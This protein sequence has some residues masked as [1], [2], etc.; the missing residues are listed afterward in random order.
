MQPKFIFLV[1]FSTMFASAAFAAAD[2]AVSLD[3]LVNEAVAHNPELAFYTAEIDAARAGQRTAA[4][5]ADP[6]LTVSGGQKRVKDSTGMLVGEGAAWSV[7]IAQTFDWPGR[8]ALRKSIANRQLALA[9]LGLARFQAALRARARTLAYGLLAAQEKAAAAS[10]VASRYAAL[11]EVFLQREPAGL[12][13]LLE[14]R[15]IEAQELALQRRATTATLAAQAALVELNQLRGAALDANLQAAPARLAFNPA[16]DLA[17]LLAAARENNFEYRGARLELEAQGFSVALARN[18]RRPSVMVAPF[19]SQEKAGDRETT[20]GLGLTIPLSVG[21]RAGANASLA[22]ARRR[23][24][25]A[26]AVVAQ[27]QMEREVIIAAQTF[28]VKMTEVGR[29]SPDSAAK[30]REAA[31][32]A[33]R[34]Y[35]LGAVPLATY[36]EL[37]NSYLD[38][39]EALYETQLE[40]LAAGQQLELLTGLNFRAAELA[41]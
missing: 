39:V 41:P 22:E 33:D 28:A 32:L 34:H 19:L 14:T 10:E 29:W 1:L 20:F 8:L 30:F 18:E 15:V 31:E 17:A 25:E 4:L 7:S 40:T 12:T 16:P 37:Q 26:A 9:E 38:A 27:R 13:P 11:R 35:R 6:E 23:Q 5:R 24:A 2:A 21:G 3:A 36:V